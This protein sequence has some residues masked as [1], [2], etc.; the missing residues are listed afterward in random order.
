LRHIAELIGMQIR[1]FAYVAM[2][3]TFSSVAN[4][5]AQMQSPS[6]SLSASSVTRTI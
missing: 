3:F 4:S 2:K 5:A 6:F 1:P